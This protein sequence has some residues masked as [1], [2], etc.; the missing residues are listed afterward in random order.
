MF[1]TE[2]LWILSLAA[3]VWFWLDSMRT[4]E[5]ARNIGRHACEK[6]EVLFL[7]DTVVL[8]KIRMRR[9]TNGQ[10]TLYREYQFEFTS[11]GSQR[12]KGKIALNG[13]RLID[14]QLEAHRIPQ[15]YTCH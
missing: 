9:N 5:L 3:V 4:N 10:M 8:Q 1:S 11:D 7:D 6:S 15:E 12:Y 14:V 13:K 2:L